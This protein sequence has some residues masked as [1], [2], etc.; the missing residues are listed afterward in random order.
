MELIFYYFSES[1]FRNRLY[2]PKVLFLIPYPLNSAPSQRFRFEQ[3]IHLLKANNI[4][5]VFQSFIGQETWSILYSKGNLYLK[6]NGFFSGFFRRITL[7]T[8][9]F[10]YEYV[11]IHREAS[12]VGPPVFE[13]F[14]AK[15]L[16]RKIIYDFDDAIWMAQTGKENFL[17]KVAKNPGKVNKIIK[18]SYKISCGNSYLKNHAQEFNKNVMINPTTIDTEGLHFK[19]KDQNTDEVVIGWTGTHSTMIYLEQAIPFLR[20]LYQIKE[21][22]LLVISNQKPDFEFP[23]MKFVK[24]NEQTEQEDLLAMNI[25]IMPLA[26]NEWTRGKC[27]FKALQYMALGIPALVSPVGVNTEI[28]DH[29]INGFVCDSE[30]DWLKHLTDLIDNAQLRSEMGKKARE[31]I[32]NKYSVK[33]NQENFLSLFS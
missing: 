26:D 12:P 2:M 10:R 1:I 7:L 17:T 9:A 5:P 32:V 8:T 15:V 4:V 28:V 20:K 3:Y 31:K 14:F 18:W 29:G 13:W 24:W 6:I 11:F 30:I 21:F 16:R 19:L 22:K 23:Q 25:G 33:S 27:G